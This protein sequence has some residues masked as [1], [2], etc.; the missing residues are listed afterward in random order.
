MPVDSGGR[1]DG[2]HVSRMEDFPS[3]YPCNRAHVR[4]RLTGHPGVR[5]ALRLTGLKHRCAALTAKDGGQVC[6]LGT[7]PV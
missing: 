7:I 3:G 6:T 2:V 5:V 4:S 1:R